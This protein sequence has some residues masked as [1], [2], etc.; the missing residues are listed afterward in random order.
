[1]AD[2]TTPEPGP[3]GPDGPVTPEQARRER[4]A[5]LARLESMLSRGVA[6]VGLV[7]LVGFVFLSAEKKAPLAVTLALIGCFMLAKLVVAVLGLAARWPL[8]PAVLLE[9][10]AIGVVAFIVAGR[11]SSLAFVLLVAVL[12]AGATLWRRRAV[13]ALPK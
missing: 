6:V 5:D 13:A 10:A 12:L 11:S 1:M 7:A 4:W 8:V 2:E 9:V 3:E